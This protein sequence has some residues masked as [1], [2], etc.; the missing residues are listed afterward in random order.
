[1]SYAFS[2][3]G[4]TKVCNISHLLSL[5]IPK[6]H[7]LLLLILRSSIKAFAEGSV[8][9]VKDKSFDCFRYDV[10]VMVLLRILS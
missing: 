4:L 9:I 7:K 8:F 5:Y 3:T 10:C 2:L 1:M 6:Y